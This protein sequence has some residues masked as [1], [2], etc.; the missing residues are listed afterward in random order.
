MC[1]FG[2]VG[3]PYT[4]NVVVALLYLS[5]TL[6]R[7]AYFLDLEFLSKSDWWKENFPTQ[8]KQKRLKNKFVVSSH[9]PDVFL[10]GNP[11]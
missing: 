6:W 11:D 3:G 9:I 5:D 7:L 2:S 4:W 8:S 10:R 1:G